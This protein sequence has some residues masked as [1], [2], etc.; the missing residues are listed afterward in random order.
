MHIYATQFAKPIRLDSIDVDIC[1][2][3]FTFLSLSPS[4]LFAI[5]WVTDRDALKLYNC[6]IIQMVDMF[7]SFYGSA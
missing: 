5:N 4:N 3:S 6:L 2:Q 1:I 7:F